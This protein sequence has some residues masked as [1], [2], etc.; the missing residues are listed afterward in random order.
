MNRPHS[1]PIIK[2][3]PGWVFVWR[4]LS[5]SP[6]DGMDRSTATW[7]HSGEALHESGRTWAWNRLPRLIRAATRTGIITLTVYGIV[8]YLVAPLTT[9]AVLSTVVMLGG[10]ALAWRIR[11]SW[12]RYSHTKTVVRP[13]AKGLAPLVHETPREVESRLVVPRNTDHPDVIVRVGLPEYWNQ[14]T[15]KDITRVVSQ[16]LGGEWMAREQLRRIP[17]F[18]EYRHRPAPPEYLDFAMVEHLLREGTDA[19][20]LLGLGSESET[21]RLD[22]NGEIAHMGLSIGTGGGKSSMMRFLLCQ[23]YYHGVRDFLVIDPKLVSLAGMEQ[24]PGMRIVTDVQESWD[25]IAME[26]AEM[27]RR[28]SILARNPKA[29]FRRRIIVLEE[30]NA[31]SLETSVVWRQIKSKSDPNLAPVWSDI[32]LLLLKARQV[33]MNMLGVY[34]RMTADACGGGSFRDQYGLKLLSRFSIQA[35]DTLVGTRPRGV[36]SAIPGRGI[37]VLGGL[38][39][40]VQVPFVTLDQAVTF[41]LSSPHSDAHPAGWVAPVVSQGREG[42][43]TPA[44]RVSQAGCETPSEAG[45]DDGSG[46]VSLARAVSEGILTGTLA[47][48]R[49]ARTR[50]PKFPQ[51]VDKHGSELLYSRDDLSEYNNSRQARVRRA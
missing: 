36:S 44:Q 48:A 16:R 41:A 42:D 50:D 7:L 18:L 38:H 40:S 9:L 19:T 34:Q 27:D 43:P 12:K 37:A 49:Q 25:A 3:H 30:Q 14:P 6:L 10:S 24:L 45:S 2:R 31:F 39:R 28:Y 13:L 51:P 15:T 8:G 46:P 20:P 17:F 47:A 32:A 26:R 29:T 21:I 1:S 5:G 35:W 4:F 22:F 23:F 11:R 33:N